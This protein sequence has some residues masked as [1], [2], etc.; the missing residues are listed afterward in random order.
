MR[1]IL[2]IGILALIIGVIFGAIYGMIQENKI[3]KSNNNNQQIISIAQNEVDQQI[4]T[5]NIK[6][7]SKSKELVPK[8]YKGY[9]VVANLKIDKLNIDTS[10]LGDYTNS[11]MYTC[12]TKFFGPDPNEVGNFCITGHNYITKNMFGY[13]KK[14]K[15][16]DNIKL[17]DNK[18]GEVQYKVYDVYRTE[19]NETS[20]IITTNK[21][22]KRSY[23]NYMLQLFR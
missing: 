16:G 21:R 2:K 3:K 14:L 4:N 22:K 9:K 12:V 5:E 1:K 8:E 11:A 23:F 6:E 18:N 13:L 7:E 10:V 20:R 15:V 19:A 17:T